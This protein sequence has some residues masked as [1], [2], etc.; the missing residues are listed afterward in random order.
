MIDIG[1]LLQ[2]ILPYSFAVAMTAGV[3][4]V[5]A[6]DAYYNKKDILSALAVKKNVV[7]AR[8]FIVIFIMTLLFAEFLST[9]PHDLVNVLKKDWGV[10][11]LYI[12]YES[13]LLI[14]RFIIMK[15]S[16]FPD[17]FL[18][19]MY[20]NLCNRHDVSGGFRV[21]LSNNAN[22]ELWT[23]AQ[24]LH[25]LLGN[26]DTAK[27]VQYSTEAINFYDG[28]TNKNEVLWSNNWKTKNILLVPNFWAIISMCKIISKNTYETILPNGMHAKT[29][30]N[31][32]RGVVSI[33]ELQQ[34]TGGWGSHS[35]NSVYRYFPTTMAIWA[36]SE[37]LRI[38]DFLRL[39]SAQR[40]KIETAIDSAVQLLIQDYNKDLALWPNV[41]GRNPKRNTVSLSLFSFAVLSIVQKTHYYSLKQEG[42]LK[43]FLKSIHED[44]MKHV[45][46]CL[47]K[48][49]EDIETDEP[50][51]NETI[52]SN[53]V[54]SI[55]FYDWLPVAML[56]IYASKLNGTYKD[57]YDSIRE[58]RIRDITIQHVDEMNDWYSYRLAVMLIGISINKTIG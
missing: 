53:G 28:L 21:H 13:A 26:Y 31:V 39:E 10:I 12:A 58:K 44:M 19:A 17:S 20:S 36:L 34:P 24:V 48:D 7:K 47:G 30:N 4:A 40:G 25:G 3:V 33:L 51:D 27:M 23:T 16:S 55:M 15:K 14:T 9:V 42:Q 8:V 5:I 46:Y 45:D 50:Y 49:I 32:T 38:N 2:S 41:P 43:D 54:T 57:F 6:L 1:G 22:V 18:K 56:A 29:I 37:A 11:A 35:K 52:D